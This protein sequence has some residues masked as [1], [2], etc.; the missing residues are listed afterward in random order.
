MD[1][2]VISIDDHIDL[3]WLPEDLWTS[4]LP[5]HLRER[6]PQVVATDSGPHWQCDGVF[7]GQWVPYGTGNQWALERVPGISQEGDRRPSTPDMR[8][9]D[10]DRDG[11]DASILYG[12]TDPF[13]IADPELRRASYEAYNDWLLEFCSHKPERLIGV[14]ELSL[15]D[16][17]AA[18]DELLRLAKKGVRHF[19]ILAARAEPQVY[20][21][22]WEP[23]WAAAEETGIPIGF[24]LAVLTGR[25][26]R[27]ESQEQRPTNE[28]VD[29]ASRFARGHPGFQ[30]IEPMTGLIFAGVLDRHPKLK[31]VMAESGLAWIPN[32]I[33]AMERFLNRV[34]L[35]HQSAGEGTKLPDLKP[36]EYF[37]RQIWMKFQDDFYGIKMLNILPEDKVM[38]GSDYPHPASTWP[39]SQE[40]IAQLM[41]GIPAETQRKVLVDNARALYGM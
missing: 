19:N 10:M 38:W 14:A 30:L 7:W 8:L 36:Y 29:Q 26:G 35:G 17:I 40:I 24:H 20:E 21:D 33:Q 41:E 37:E 18:R 3:R 25:V 34:R 16:P 6:G 5:V 22:A 31:I 15:Q 4:R 39:N 2:R 28:L 13:N 11:V 12:P 9:A 1:Y 23:F 27:Q 32:M